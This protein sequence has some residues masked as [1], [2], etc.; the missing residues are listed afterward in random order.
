[1]SDLRHRTAEELHAVITYENK[2]IRR[3]KA[4]IAGAQVRISWAEHYLQE[5]STA[6]PLEKAVEKGVLATFR[7]LPLPE[8]EKWQGTMRCPAYDTIISTREGA[9]IVRRYTRDGKPAGELTIY[10]ETEAHA[11]ARL[12]TNTLDEET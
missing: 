8:D 7:F 10:S 9:Y 6:S 5:R 4:Q 1:M 2:K 3:L 12:L 11:L